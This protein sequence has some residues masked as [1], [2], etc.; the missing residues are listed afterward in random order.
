MKIFSWCQVNCTTQKRMKI[1]L[2]GQVKS[3]IQC[4]DSIPIVIRNNTQINESVF[5]LSSTT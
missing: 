4:E 2:G 3:N 5:M 1:Y